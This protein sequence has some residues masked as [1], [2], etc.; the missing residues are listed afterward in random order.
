MFDYSPLILEH[1]YQPRHIGV[2]D[3]NDSHVGTG[4]IGDLNSIC[5]MQ[6]HINFDKEER[7]T[8]ARFK[9]HGCVAAIATMSWLCE[10]LIGKTITEVTA[11]KSA[12]LFQPLQLVPQKYYCALWAEDVLK[13]A[14][15][16]YHK[17]RRL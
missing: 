4:R 10:Y 11:L 14:V 1:F 13:L 8:A 3:E 15:E 12:V 7:I 16:D 17:K 9:V 5:V 2:L 6:V